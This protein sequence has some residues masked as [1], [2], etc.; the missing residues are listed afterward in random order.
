M[1]AFITGSKGQ[2]GAAFVR[3]LDANGWDY[4]AADIDTLDITDGNAVMDALLPYRPGLILNCAAYNLVDKAETEGAKAFA[5][6]AEGPRGL[7]LAARK[8]ESTLVHFGTDYI[9]DGAKAAPYTEADAPNP[10]NNYGRSKLK[11]EEYVLQAP[12][13][14]VLRL[15]WVYGRGEQNFMHKLR[16]WAANPGPLRVASDEISVPTCTED[17]VLV[18]LEAL[19]RG[20]TGAWHLTNTGHCSRYDWA[21]LALEE[22]GISKEVVP[23][24]MA[25]FKTAARRPGYSAMSNAALSAE[26]GIKIPAWEDSVAAY[27]R[28]NK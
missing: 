17:V 2:L 25:E 27:I 7:A 13:S 24:R 10:L 16:G 5:V 12:G 9:F 23:A 8:L 1:R 14:L 21:K 3:H 20:L 11:G 15:S 28:G 22:Y 18:A 4:A 6:N 26:L 19:K